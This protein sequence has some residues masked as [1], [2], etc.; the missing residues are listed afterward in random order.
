MSVTRASC[1]NL[2]CTLVMTSTSVR[3]CAHLASVTT[4]Y[5]KTRA[6]PSRAP[7]LPDTSSPPAYVTASVR[8]KM[9]VS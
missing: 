9:L 2:Q 6:D 1:T 4:F 7:A 8:T 3:T 5:V